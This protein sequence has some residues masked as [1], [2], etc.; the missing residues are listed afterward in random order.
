M[1]DSALPPNLRGKKHW[2][3]PWPFNKISRGATAFKWGKPKLVFGHADMADGAP[4][5]INPPDTWQFSYYPGAPWWAKPFAWYFGKSGG[6]K[7]GRYR[8]FR[9]GTR[10][11][12]VDDY[13]NCT[14]LPLPSSRQ[15]TGDPLQNTSTD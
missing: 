15:F 6:F 9:I 10:W 13:V 8:N 11:D 2:D 1:P 3:W 12:D 4:K 7:D 14:F 5:P